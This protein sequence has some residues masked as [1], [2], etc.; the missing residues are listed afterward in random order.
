M[1]L[2][3]PITTV[4]PSVQGRVLLV[5]GRTGLELTGRRVAELAGTSPERTRQV[6]RDMLR[7]GLIH[8]RRAGQAILYEANREHVM[9]PAVQQL[10]DDADQAIWTVKQRIGATLED[11]LGPD[12]SAGVTAALFG[13]VARGDSGQDSDV[14]VL[15]ITPND[16]DDAIVE[17][18]V[19]ATIRTVEAATGNDCN[20]YQA[21]REKF[22]AL[23][24]DDDPMITS[25]SADAAVFHGPDFRRRLKGA[26]WEE[27][28]PPHRTGSVS[29]PRLREST[30]R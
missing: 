3:D 29:E 17:H 7:N 1:N 4:M 14:D 9:W 13:S 15:L 22:D 16:L 26:R 25:W 12:A 6:L 28:V 10:V 30:I 8:S 23:A 18:T 11:T 2:S 20:V 27:L 5:I 24:H 19:V 21:S